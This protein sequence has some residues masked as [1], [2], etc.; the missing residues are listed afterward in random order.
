MTDRAKCGLRVVELIGAHENMVGIVGRDSEDRNA[1]VG[2][3]SGEIGDDTG[4]SEIERPGHG[5]AAKIALD[6]GLIGT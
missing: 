5:E 1:G 4:Q 3:R 2:Q 6:F